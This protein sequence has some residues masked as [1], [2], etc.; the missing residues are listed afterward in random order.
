VKAIAELPQQMNL[1]FLSPLLLSWAS[2]AGAAADAAVP[3]PEADAA[4]SP[5]ALGQTSPAFPGHAT[6]PPS[7]WS[8]ASAWHVGKAR[9]G[10]I[11]FA[12][13]R[14]QLLVRVSSV[15]AGHWQSHS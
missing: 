9:S 7:R 15:T 10:V 4:C 13:G 8:S 2:D 11:P 5:P 12:G 1:P 6:A 3:T 14:G